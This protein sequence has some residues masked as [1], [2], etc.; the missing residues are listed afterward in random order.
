[1]NDHPSPELQRSVCIAGRFTEALAAALDT[2][3][4]QLADPTSPESQYLNAPTYNPEN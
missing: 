4:K 3:A 1:M 2:V